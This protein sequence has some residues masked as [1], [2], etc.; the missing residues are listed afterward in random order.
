MNPKQPAGPPKENRSV[1]IA[2]RAGMWVF[3]IVVVLTLFGSFWGW[4]FGS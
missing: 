3:W 4:L 1:T 2:W